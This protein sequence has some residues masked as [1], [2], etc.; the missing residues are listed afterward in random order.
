MRVP[1]P[2]IYPRAGPKAGQEKWKMTNCARRQ[3][4]PERYGPTT[5]TRRDGDQ[6]DSAVRLPVQ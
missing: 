6:S 2:F 3:R 5:P 1:V 4:L